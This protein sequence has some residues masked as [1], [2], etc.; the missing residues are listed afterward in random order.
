MPGTFRLVLKCPR[1]P[2]G[3]S[4]PRAWRALRAEGGRV[5]SVNQQPV[6]DDMHGPVLDRRK[7][8][9][10]ALSFGPAGGQTFRVRFTV[11][12]GLQSYVELEKS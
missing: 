5:L 3:V 6:L 1:P 7:L 11:K 10:P 2:A 12:Y 9:P 8:R 4:L